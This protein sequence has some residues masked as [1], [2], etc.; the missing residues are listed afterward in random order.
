MPTADYRLAPPPTMVDGLLAVPVHFQDVQATVRF[1]GAA[2]T[3]RADVTVTYE[4]GPTTGSPLFDLRQ[5]IDQAWV[6]GAPA[7]PDG[8][9]ARDLG[10]GSF[11]T[12]R[13]LETVQAAG[14]VHTLRVT[15]WLDTPDCQLGGSYPPVVAWSPGPRL[16]WTLGMSDLNA[17]RYLEAWL[18][19]N[20]IW[21]RFPVRL[22]VEVT[23]TLAA[24]SIITNGA[25]TALGANHW[26]VQFPGHFAPLP[27]LLEIRASDTVESA[28][29]S[30]TLPLTGAVAIE[31]WKLAGGPEDL[32]ARI[33]DIGTFL[34]A[35]ETD[36]GPYLHGRIVVFFNG[37]GGGMEYAGATTTSGSALGHELFHSWFARGVTPA[38]QADGWWDEAFTTFHDDGADDTQPFDFL[39]PPVELCSR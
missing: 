4:V 14:S 10:A 32:T 38:S 5:T 8:L 31:A 13:V 3:G 6:D 15:Y 35:N 11:S 17:G 22:D 9:A 1:D 23:G 30:A 29:G 24:H 37:A 12:V 33:A 28:T 27:Q 36:Y 2:A 25:V 18:P 21:D 34:R 7:D 26:S 16:R 19:S 39:E 20:L